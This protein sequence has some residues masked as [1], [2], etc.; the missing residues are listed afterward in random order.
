LIPLR[1]IDEGLDGGGGGAGLRFFIPSGLSGIT[2]EAEATD[3]V[4]LERDVD[5]VTD[6]ATDDVVED[7]ESCRCIEGRR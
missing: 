7:H 3:V 1:A 2:V 4:A 6:V 5:C